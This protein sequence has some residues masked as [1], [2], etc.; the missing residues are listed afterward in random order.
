[1]TVSLIPLEITVSLTPLEITVAIL[2]LHPINLHQ[3]STDIIK[4]IISEMDV[5]IL[6][7]QVQ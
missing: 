1:M 5:S 2:N 7:S 6:Y 4:T 3:L